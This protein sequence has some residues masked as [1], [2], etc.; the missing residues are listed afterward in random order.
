[1]I[2]LKYEPQCS[3]DH[4]LYLKDSLPDKEYQVYFND[5]LS[6]RA[7]YRNNRRD[8]NWIHYHKDGTESYVEI[9]VNGKLKLEEEE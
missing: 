9:Y 8:G 3:M 5:T 6:Y 1:M 7:F 2:F 4:G